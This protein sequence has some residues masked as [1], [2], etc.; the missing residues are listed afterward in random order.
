LRASAASGAAPYLFVFYFCHAECSLPDQLAHAEGSHPV[1]WANRIAQSALIAV[2]EGFSSIHSN[3]IRDLF[4][5]GY[6]LHSTP[7]KTKKC[8]GIHGTNK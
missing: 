4:K 7:A 1:P 3:A 2:L 6:V 8:H 5:I